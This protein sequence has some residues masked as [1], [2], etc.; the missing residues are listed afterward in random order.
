MKF[1]NLALRLCKRS[2]HRQHAHAAVVVSGG[3]I[4]AMGSNIGN[5]HAEVHA[6]KQLWPDHR[7][8]TKVYSFR[9]TKSGSWAMAKPCPKCEAY[10]RANGV[11]VVY[12]TDRTGKLVRFKL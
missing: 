1:D 8:N 5:I 7:A 6:L 11:K 9:F 4:V 2:T 12:Y 3:A 10:M